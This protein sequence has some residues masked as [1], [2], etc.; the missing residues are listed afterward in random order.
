MPIVNVTFIFMGILIP[1][2]ILSPIGKFS[3]NLTNFYGYA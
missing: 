2:M 3:A 1:N